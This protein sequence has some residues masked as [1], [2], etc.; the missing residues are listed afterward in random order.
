MV[1]GLR[2]TTVT[3]GVSD[4]NSSQS[5]GPHVH[6]REAQSLRAQ[7]FRRKCGAWQPK[8]HGHLPIRHS[9]GI[10]ILHNNPISKARSTGAPMTLMS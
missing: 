7:R 9:D 10:S 1:L 2:T 3:K 6:Y 5:K 8:Q 4:N